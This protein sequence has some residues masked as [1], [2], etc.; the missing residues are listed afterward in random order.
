MCSYYPPCRAVS[1]GVLEG[2]RKLRN[3]KYGWGL[4]RQCLASVQDLSVETERGELSKYVVVD[5]R[6]S[7]VW[8]ACVVSRPVVG[9]AN[10]PE[11]ESSSSSYRGW[12]EKVSRGHQS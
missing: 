2:G 10:G 7:Q 4:G 11:S 5:G 6:I 12:D 3:S 9:R 1:S 8:P